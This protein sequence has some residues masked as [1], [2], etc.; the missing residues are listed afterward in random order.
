VNLLTYSEQLDN[1]AWTKTNTTVSANAAVAPDGT[2]T[3]DE[4]TDTTANSWHNVEL[5][6]NFPTPGTTTTAYDISWRVKKNTVRY[7]AI[8]WWRDL[9]NAAG[10]GFDLDTATVTGTGAIGTSYAA[11]NASMTA[12]GNGWFECRVRVTGPVLAQ[13]PVL[14]NRTTAYAGGASTWLGEA[15][16]GSTSN[17]TL[18]WGADVRF[19]T[20]AALP[21]QRVVTA[22]DYADV[23]AP[24]YLTFDGVD[25][26]LYTAASVDF[27][28]WTSGTRRNLLTYPSAFD[29][30]A[31]VK[32]GLTVSANTTTAPDGSSTAD[33]VAEDTSTGLHRFYGSSTVAGTVGLEYVASVFAKADE[34]SLL[35]L[36]AS[37]GGT[38]F[39]VEFNLS[40][41]TSVTRSGTVSNVFVT[42]VGNGWVRCGFTFVSTGTAAEYQVRVLQTANTISYAG[43]AG[44]GLFLWGA[45]LELGST[46]T[47][48][49]DVGTDKMTV[50]TGV[51]KLSDG[52]ASTIGIV[53]ETSAD[54]ASNAGAFWIAAPDRANGG[55]LYDMLSR[56]T[57]FTLAGTTA[58]AYTAPSTNVLTGLSDIS[59]PLLRFRVDGVQT[60]QSTA[61]QGAGT[62]GTY[63]LYVGRRNNASLPFNG[64]LYQLIVR[65][66][67]TDTA[68]V[69]QTER[70]VAGK[71]GLVI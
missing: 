38:A 47:A 39:V 18:L 63:V 22:S 6:S 23:Q 42:A 37:L 55:R 10:A 13:V 30:S 12:L 69:Q 56:G 7:I 50:V 14:F 34:R 40:S 53:A 70:F 28:T 11:S 32:T 66:A 20:D 58:A 19:A 31:W 54:S 5:A 8:G 61:T 1:A 43:T 46:A 16:T 24:R 59:A 4:L 52:G 36:V 29:N 3:A 33:K 62:Y 27:A 65:G 44:S 48:F 71:T 51:R 68:T 25:D 45:Q 2:T 64:R 49:Q 21:Y 67:Q 35:Q 15:Y 41:L 9:T 26:S 57:A 60:E 17:K